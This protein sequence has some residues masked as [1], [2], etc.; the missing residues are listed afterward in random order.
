MNKVICFAAT[1][2]KLQRGR[3]ILLQEPA[4]FKKLYEDFTY[5]K[6]N[7]SPALQASNEFFASANSTFSSVA[8]HCIHALEEYVQSC[9]EPVLLAYID[10][11][12]KPEDETVVAAVRSAL[13]ALRLEDKEP[14]ELFRSFLPAETAAS[15]QEASKYQTE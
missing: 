15:I 5:I 10:F 3:C 7:S 1:V 11:F 13:A 12:E 14:T 4:D 2:R 6:G 9:L 8:S